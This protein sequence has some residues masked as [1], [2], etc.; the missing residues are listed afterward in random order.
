M[1]YKTVM[2]QM[3]Q[4]MQV[5]GEKCLLCHFP[6]TDDNLIK[7]KCGHYYHRECIENSIDKKVYFTCFYCGFKE[8]IYTNTPI[9]TCTALI[10]SGIKRGQVCGRVNCSYHKVK[11]EIKKCSS[12][13]KTGMKKGQICG[14]INC[15]YHKA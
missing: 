15:S 8:N 4:M 10:K 9:N 11:K 1:D 13:I 6:D 5:K 12:I 14:R 2:K 7:L 3:E